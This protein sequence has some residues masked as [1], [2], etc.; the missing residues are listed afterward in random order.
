MPKGEFL[1]GVDGSG[2]TTQAVIA[3]LNGKFLGRGLALPSNH[4]RVGFEKAARA[5]GMA[6]DG[7]LHQVLGSRGGTSID[8]LRGRVAAACF[9]LAGMARPE[10]Q[11]LL[12]SWVRSQG[13]TENFVVINDSELILGGGAPQGWG[14]AVI[15]GMGSICFARGQD[16]RTARVGGWGHI[17]GDEGSG[18]SIAS[19]ALHLAT[20][21]ADHRANARGV[22]QTVLNHCGLKTPE[23]LIGYLYRPEMPQDT[24]AS[25]V[26]P[27]LDLALSGDPDARAI[28][29]QAA[30]ALAVHVDTI[31]RTLA[32]K[33]PPLALG[34]SAMRASLRNALVAHVGVEIGPVTVVQ[35]PAS[36]AVS[37]ARGLLEPAT[38][39]S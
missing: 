24:I 6:V 2:A 29:D 39:V 16:G 9:G 17:A 1:L 11:T 35:D 31:V 36:A 15:S 20:Q 4:H 13:Y 7:A 33:R 19:L 25:L 37:I 38:R 22:L 5:L 26:V 21:T 12:S 27:V 32:L 30:A 10:D 8:S 23:E 18:Y 14:V 28:V 34:G 3:D